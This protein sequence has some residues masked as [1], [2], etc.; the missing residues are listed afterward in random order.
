MRY[1]DDIIKSIL[2]FLSNVMHSLKKSD[3]SKIFIHNYNAFNTDFPYSKFH[4]LS[5]DDCNFIFSQKYRVIDLTLILPNF[6]EIAIEIYLKKRLI[7]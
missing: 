3:I 6:V 5:I 1:G 4:D 2:H 7:M